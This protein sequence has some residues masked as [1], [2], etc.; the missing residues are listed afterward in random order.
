MA[1]TS[2]GPGK[3]ASARSR[4]K[5]IVTI[6]DSTAPRVQWASF[7]TKNVDGEQEKFQ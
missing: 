5:G 6:T 4:I 1:G 3:R 7:G 2:G